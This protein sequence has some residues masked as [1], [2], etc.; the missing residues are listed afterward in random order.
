ME[1]TGR[2]W[3][4]LGRH[5]GRVMGRSGVHVSLSVMERTSTRTRTRTQPYYVLYV[6]YCIVPYSTGLAITKAQGLAVGERVQH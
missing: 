4:Q 5:G 6:L 3:L 1:H 2:T